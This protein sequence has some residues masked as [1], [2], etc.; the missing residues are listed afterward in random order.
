MQVLE[1]RVSG[2][3][4]S[5]ALSSCRHEVGTTTVAWSLARYVSGLHEQPVVLVEANL[6]KPVL[7]ESLELSSKPGFK[8][9]AAGTANLDEVTQELA[10]ES[11]S[12]ITAGIGSD[13]PRVSLSQMRMQSAVLAIRK[14]YA[15]AIFDTAPFLAYPDTV[16][17]AR[18]LDGVVLI[19]E[20]E[21]DKWEVAK[22]AI[23]TAADAGVTMLGSILNKKPL[24]IPTWLYGR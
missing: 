24:Y 3:R 23:E 19:L 1:R 17:I 11:F 10:G 20:A 2:E 16:S 12:I 18:H 15:V 4:L 7:A 6:R 14:K 13:E 9:L 8:A 22:M 21:Q 5:I